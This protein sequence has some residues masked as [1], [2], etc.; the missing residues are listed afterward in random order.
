GMV[1]L[2]LT[3]CWVAPTGCLAGP[4][5]SAL[6][7]AVTAPRSIS[8]CRV[9]LAFHAP[10]RRCTCR[11]PGQRLAQPAP[12]DP[13]SSS[14]VLQWSK[15]AR[16]GVPATRVGVAQL[17]QPF[18]VLGAQVQARRQLL[19][20]RQTRDSLAVF[21]PEQVRRADTYVPRHRSDA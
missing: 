10:T 17:D 6:G 7:H 16:V 3:V 21:Q 13:R 4:W 15:I 20:D 18:S 1:V 19:S 8:R 5:A 11:S 12:E 14:V 2:L 9:A